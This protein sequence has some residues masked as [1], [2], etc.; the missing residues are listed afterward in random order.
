MREAAV[1]ASVNKIIRGCTQ[2][3]KA[4]GKR[5]ALKHML[6]EVHRLWQ[7][8]RPYLDHSDATRFSKTPK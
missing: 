3:S 7:L 8:L 6:P 2:H 4:T 1:H 5:D